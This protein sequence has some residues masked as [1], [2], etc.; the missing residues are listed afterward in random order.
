MVN[1]IRL[2]FQ[3]LYGRFYQWFFN[4]T[5][6]Y[7]QNFYSEQLK[8][9]QPSSE[10]FPVLWSCINLL[11]SLSSYVM[12]HLFI[13]QTSHC[14]WNNKG[15]K[16]FFFQLSGTKKCLTFCNVQNSFPDQ[17]QKLAIDINFHL[18]SRFCCVQKLRTSC[19]TWM[20]TILCISSKLK[21]CHP[22]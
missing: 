12:C 1:H 21:V 3:G 14:H 18:N 9:V 19:C 17:T 20:I 7:Y 8:Y 13:N 4:V 11:T 2:I 5:S 10:T 6:I 16:L 22:A 15:S